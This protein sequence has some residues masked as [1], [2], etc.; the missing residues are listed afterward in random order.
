MLLAN[1]SVAECI[2]RAFPQCALLRRH[3]A[4]PAAQYGP[5]VRAA[6][7]RGIRLDTASSS[8]LLHSLCRTVADDAG[9]PMATLLRIL[10]TRCLA[11]AVYFSSGTRR[12]GDYHHFGL[13]MPIYTHFT[14]PIRRYADLIVHRL[15]ACAIGAEPTS[16]ILPGCRRLQHI[17]NHLNRR[18]RMAQYAARASVALET[19]LLL[20]AHPCDEDGYVLA[21]RP[22]AVTVFV[23][24]Y[25]LEGTIVLDRSSFGT[26]DDRAQAFTRDGSVTLRLFDRVRVHLDVRSADDGEDAIHM[27]LSTRTER[28]PAAASAVAGDTAAAAPRRPSTKRPH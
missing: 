21:V 18:H 10:A 12:P 19:L 11:Q 28:R 16:A 9:T 27:Q 7:A 14:S 25:A 22:D 15:L 26:Y 13:A 5:L 2:H 6:L 4:P 23:P 17:A 20:R 8:A 24:R 3:A 1:V